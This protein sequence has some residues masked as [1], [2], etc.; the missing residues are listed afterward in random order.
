M[1]KGID[2]L[3][4]DVFIQDFHTEVIFYFHFMY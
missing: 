3:T 4:I 2:P 1:F